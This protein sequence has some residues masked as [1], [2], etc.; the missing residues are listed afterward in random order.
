MELIAIGIKEKKPQI[1]LCLKSIKKPD[2]FKNEQGGLSVKW[3]GLLSARAG[4]V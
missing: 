3:N 1:F 4:G 2:S